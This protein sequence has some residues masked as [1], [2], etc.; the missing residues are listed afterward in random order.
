MNKIE[1]IVNTP[2]AQSDK[3][4]TA[5]LPRRRPHQLGRRRLNPG[6]R[7]YD[8]GSRWNGSEYEDLPY[9]APDRS[10]PITFN[11]G[12]T[13]QNPY[14]QKAIALSHYYALQGLIFETPLEEWR[15]TYR[16]VDNAYTDSSSAF[17]GRLE[18][19]YRGTSYFLGA[20]SAVWDDGTFKPDV[21]PTNTNLRVQNT[22]QRLYRSFSN[23]LSNSKWTTEY[24][25]S[26][27]SATFTPT[28]NFDVYLVPIIQPHQCVTRWNFFPTLPN[29]Q[30]DIFGF[31][32]MAWPREAVVDPLSPYFEIDIV[33]GTPGTSG[34][35]S[36]ATNYTRAYNVIRMLQV[37]QNHYASR[38]TGVSGSWSQ[39]ALSPSAFMTGGDFPTPPT[40]PTSPVTQAA[41]GTSEEAHLA[42]SLQ[43]VVRQGGITYYVWEN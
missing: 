15:V 2:D 23:Y 29:L 43:A 42:G 14:I 39:S 36:S 3:K 13:I 7:F 9:E 19:A 31:F 16:K 20:P 33:S 21:E 27:S 11:A 4:K 37:K 26:A 28:K 40:L 41:W 22:S 6:I 18:V 38:F 30:D 10:A 25:Y 17:S 32:R 1:I 12:A 8:F 24:D 5:A 35:I 34:S